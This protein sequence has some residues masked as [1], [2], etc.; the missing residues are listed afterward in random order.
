MVPA[1]YI[2]RYPYSIIWHVKK[3]FGKTEGVVLYCANTLDYHIF[4]P[5][6]KYLKPL[7]VVAKDK[8]AQQELAAIGI[9]SRTLPSFPDGVIMCRHAAYRFPAKAVKKIGLR[10]G[11]YHFKPF[12]ST[13]SYNLVDKYLMSSRDEVEKAR[14]VGIRSGVAVGFPKLDSAFDGTYDSQFLEQ[15]RN[16]LKLAADKKTILLTSTWDKSGLS[17]I[18]KWIT[19]LNSL[20]DQYNVLVTVHPWVSQDYIDQITS[21]PGVVF[22]GKQD[23]VPY[24]MLADVCVGDNSSIL[25]ECCAL[26]KPMVTFKVADGKRTV[27]HVRDMIREFSIQ[28]D[29]TQDLQQA[30]DRCI[31]NPAELTEQ[32]KAANKIMF[33]ELDGKAGLRAAQQIL[34]LFPQL[35]KNS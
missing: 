13:E 11:A 2:F 14:A 12:A 17:A 32:R 4:S 28:I 3:Y 15:L 1:Y 16:Q 6:Q 25:A 33:D 10:H 8:K 20:T 18:D 34:E 27:P 19:E 7:P 21:T 23:A 30:I 22:V 29:S 5:V 9:E 26:D 31:Q 35:A 24:I